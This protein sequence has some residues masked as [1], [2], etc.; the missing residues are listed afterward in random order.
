M[1]QFVEV[2]HKKIFIIKVH[3]KRISPINSRYSHN[4]KSSWNRRSDA[5]LS[6]I[7]SYSRG[8]RG[9]IPYFTKEQLLQLEILPDLNKLI[10]NN[11]FSQSK[12]LNNDSIWQVIDA[13]QFTDYLINNYIYVIEAIE[14]V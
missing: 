4:R 8:T 10:I 2:Q 5:V 14:T 11:I 13:R 12:D 7:E 3:N 1:Y 6:I 9:E